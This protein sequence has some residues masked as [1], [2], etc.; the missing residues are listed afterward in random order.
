VEVELVE[1]LVVVE[2]LVDLEKVKL[3][4]ALIH[5]VQLLAHQAL[6]MVYQSQLLDIQ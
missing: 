6:I 5:K 4:N 3:L 1:I 2:E